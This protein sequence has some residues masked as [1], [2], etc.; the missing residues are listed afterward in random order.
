MSRPSWIQILFMMRIICRVNISWRRSSPDWTRKRFERACSCMSRWTLTC[1]TLYYSTLKMTL[2]LSPSGSR[3]WKDSFKGT[4]LELKKEQDWNTKQILITCHLF[5]ACIHVRHI[6]GLT[7]WVSHN[8]KEMISLRN[9]QWGTQDTGLIHSTT[10]L[11]RMSIHSL[12]CIFP[13]KIN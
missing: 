13:I 6:G 12:D 5:S 1:T 3:F 9:I 2:M 11:V 8:K 7:V 4:A 10:A